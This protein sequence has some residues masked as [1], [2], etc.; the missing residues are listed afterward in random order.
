MKLPSRVAY[1]WKLLLFGCRLKG[2]FG[3]NVG[4]S[5][6]KSSDLGH[7][8]LPR[9]ANEWRQHSTSRGFVD[10]FVFETRFISAVPGAFL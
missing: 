6:P 8:E 7:P 10:N 2:Y 3:F 9:P 5:L 4:T 1:I